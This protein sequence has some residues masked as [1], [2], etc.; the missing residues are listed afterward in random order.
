[1]RICNAWFDFQLN[2]DGYASLLICNLLLQGTLENREK[3]GLLKDGMTDQ[4]VQ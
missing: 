4:K 2:K 3:F 1:M